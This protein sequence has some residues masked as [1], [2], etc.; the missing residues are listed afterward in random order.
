MALTSFKEETA[1]YIAEKMT[2]P[3]LWS[4]EKGQ[5][6]GNGFVLAGGIAL[7]GLWVNPPSP[8]LFIDEAP[9]TNFPAMLTP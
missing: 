5:A 1:G 7:G 9:E 2:G 6:G 3:Q 8:D 4:V